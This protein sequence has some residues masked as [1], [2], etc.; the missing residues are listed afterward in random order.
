MA[1]LRF[2]QVNKLLIFIFFFISLLCHCRCELH[3]YTW[4]WPTGLGYTVHFYSA[5]LPSLGII[6]NS[7]LDY[8]FKFIDYFPVMSNLLLI[9]CSIFFTEAISLLHMLDFGPSYLLHFLYH[10]VYNFLKLFDHIEHIYTRCSNVLSPISII[11]F[12]SGFVLIGWTIS[13]WVWFC[14]WMVIFNCMLRIVNLGC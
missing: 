2:L 1:G 14:A 3:Y 13:S 6:L 9:T 7:C 4:Y 8:L 11:F 12:I 10:D 5:S